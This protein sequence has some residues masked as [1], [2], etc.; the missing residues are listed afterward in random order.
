MIE[1]P[2]HTEATQENGMNPEDER[3]MQCTPNTIA[4]NEPMVRISPELRRAYSF[5]LVTV[6][7]MGS[8]P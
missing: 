5:M 6:P 3:L 1:A 8:S 7:S 2:G 4:P